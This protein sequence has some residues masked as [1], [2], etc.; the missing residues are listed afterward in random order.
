MLRTIG[1][2]DPDIQRPTAGGGSAPPLVALV[3]LLAHQSAR[4]AQV[5]DANAAPTNLT[6]QT[7]TAQT[8]NAKRE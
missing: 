3:R 6:H 7:V 1:K 8:D 2:T 5:A 4:E